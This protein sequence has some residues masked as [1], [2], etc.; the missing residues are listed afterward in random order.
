MKKLTIAVLAAAWA[1]AACCGEAVFRRP[2]SRVASMD[3][4]RSS[5]VPDATCVQLVYETPLEVDYYARPYR[6]KPGLCS[7]PEVSEDG[8]VYILRLRG[9]SRFADDGCFA[10]GR[11]RAVTADDVVYS[12]NRLADKTN[13]SSGMWLMSKVE[14][15]EAIGDD[16]VKITLKAPLHVFPW[17]LAMAYTGVVPREAVEA[18]GQRFGSHPVG[19]GAYRLVKWRRNHTMEFE[20]NPAW[21]G[22]SSEA[23]SGSLGEGA[24]VGRIVYSVIDD[25]STQWLMFLKG[26]LDFLAEIT[27]DY[28]DAILVRDAEG[29]TPRLDPGLSAKGFTFWTGSALDIFYMGM[30][31]R[32][33]RLRDNKKLRQA[34]NCAFDFPKW[35]EFRKGGVTQATGPVPPG[36]T[37]RL[38]TPYEYS[39]NEQKALMLLEEAGYSVHRDEATGRMQAIDPATGRR[40]SL[41]YTLGRATQTDREEAEL[42]KSFYEKV[43]IDLELRFMTWTGFLQA[44]DEG[45]LELFRMGWVG[46]Y[47]DAENFLQLFHTRNLTPGPNHSSYSN[48]EFDEVYDRAMEASARALPEA[49]ELWAKAQEIVR[50]DAPWVFMYHPERYSLTGPRLSGYMP[51]DFPYGAERHFRLRDL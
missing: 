9:G 46:D 26:E 33:P 3:P 37:W 16:A 17:Y 25:P 34:L 18:Y 51:G 35:A 41:T 48:P 28:R 50:E 47:P 42:V 1:F 24:R 11:G 31:L 15:V 38:E 14:S 43:G 32:S 45:R 29:G 44:V 20:L 21:P 2:I 10:S 12:M 36:V 39:F 5:S 27:Q 4:I 19:S 7:L 23:D 13:A 8:R 6:L 49:G 30:N 40:L 22:W